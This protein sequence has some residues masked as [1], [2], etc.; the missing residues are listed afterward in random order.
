[1]VARKA[2]E[3]LET[4]IRAS[5]DPTAGADADAGRHA[6]PARRLGP[7]LRGA[8]RVLEAVATDLP[9][10]LRWLGGAGNR[11]GPHRWQSTRPAAPSRASSEAAAGSRSTCA[12]S[13]QSRGGL[14]QRAAA[15]RM[16]SPRIEGG[17]RLSTERTAVAQPCYTARPLAMQHDGGRLEA[18]GDGLRRGDSTL[19]HRLA[20]LRPEPEQAPP[21]LR[22]FLDGPASGAEVAAGSRSGS[23]LRRPMSW[24]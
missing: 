20:A 21:E 18:L 10:R 16:P 24:R 23:L 2:D 12:S 1:M 7:Q 15:L 3:A 13:R 19:T 9:A 8:G 5:P 14:C 6:I 4:A 17:W 11:F 22:R